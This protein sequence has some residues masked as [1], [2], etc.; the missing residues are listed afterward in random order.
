TYQ[1]SPFKCDGNLSSYNIINT[2]SPVSVILKHGTSTITP[3]S[4]KSYASVSGGYCTLWCSFGATNSGSG[5]LSLTN[6][7]TAIPDTMLNNINSSFSGG[8]RVV[9]SRGVNGAIS[10]IV[11]SSTQSIT[12]ENSNGS[13]IGV[14]DTSGSYSIIFE[15][16][17][18]IAG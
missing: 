14:S 8:G 3:S 10:A 9:R 5:S 12:F 16:T 13:T 11:D 18:K 1:T 7:P 15:V 2:K 17:Y 4:I 6:F